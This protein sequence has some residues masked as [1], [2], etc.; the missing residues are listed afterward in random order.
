VIATVPSDIGRTIQRPEPTFAMMGGAIPANRLKSKRRSGLRRR[1][2]D[3]QHTRAPFKPYAMRGRHLIA[4]SEF[5][6][7]QHGQ[8]YNLEIG[9]NASDHGFDHAEPTNFAD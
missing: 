6:R 2:G 1:R 8:L 4:T 3:A 9:G 5:R 7:I